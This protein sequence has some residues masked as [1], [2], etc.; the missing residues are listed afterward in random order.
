MLRLQRFELTEEPVVLGQLEA[1]EVREA[2]VPAV[3]QAEEAEA[4]GRGVDVAD[5][6]D[7]RVVTISRA[8]SEVEEHVLVGSNAASGLESEDQISVVERDG[9]H[10][11]RGGDDRA[12]SEKE[13]GFEE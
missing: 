8:C 2:G 7:G 6:S 3:E 10:R 11:G 4:L 1:R 13:G 9:P 5:G 12:Y